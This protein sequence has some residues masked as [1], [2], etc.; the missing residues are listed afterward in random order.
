[1][2]EDQW[3]RLIALGFGAGIGQQ[4]GSKRVEVAPAIVFVPPTSDQLADQEPF[5]PKSV[6]RR[7][8]DEKGLQ[9]SEQDVD[10]LATDLGKSISPK[11]TQLDRIRT[12]IVYLE[13][14]RQA[15][16]AFC[17]GRI[18]RKVYLSLIHRYIKKIVDLETQGG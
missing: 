16:A 8:L 2:A 4:L 3:I 17:E 6:V 1:M 14:L 10:R 13:R 12:R 18:D 9:V 15:V 5:D 7:I 11:L